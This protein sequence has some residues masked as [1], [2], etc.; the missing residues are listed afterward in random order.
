MCITYILIIETTNKMN[1]NTA[2][3]NTANTKID[4]TCNFCANTDNANALD[5][6]I[7]KYIGAR[8]IDEYYCAT[9]PYFYVAKILDL[10]VQDGKQ[11]IT[12]EVIYN[13]HLPRGHPDRDAYTIKVTKELVKHQYLPLPADFHKFPGK[14]PHILFRYYN[15]ENIDYD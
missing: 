15:E 13:M 6:Q 7:N 5:F 8:V 10:F 4:C 9:H 11:M 14:Y 12:I 3:T 1:A 2:N